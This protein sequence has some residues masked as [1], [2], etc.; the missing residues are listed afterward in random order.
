MIITIYTKLVLF[1]NCF[2]IPKGG[3]QSLR[4][5]HWP[6]TA[7]L[8]TIQGTQT[9]P[10][11]RP[12]DAIGIQ[13]ASGGPLFACGAQLEPKRAATLW[14]GSALVPRQSHMLRQMKHTKA[15]KSAQSTCALS[16][17]KR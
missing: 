16:T 14:I 17:C 11:G 15:V 8:A 1:M 9:R 2:L 5:D 12:E 13:K 7:A 6:L 4:D 3:K 10:S